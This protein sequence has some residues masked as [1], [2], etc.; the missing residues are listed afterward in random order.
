MM[1]T[2]EQVQAAYK[3]NLETLLGLTNK[4]FESVEKMAELNLAASKAALTEASTVAKATTSAKDV[5][6]VLALQASALQP[7]AEKT[8]AYSRELYDIASA[9]SAEC[10]KVCES[11]GAEAQK[12]MQDVLGNTAKNTP[13]GSEAVM[14]VIQNSMAAAN[15]AMESVQKAVKQANAV[16]DS[17]FKTMTENAVKGASASKKSK[18]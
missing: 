3:A 15:N 9:Y 8:A 13:P 7:L 10:S 12:N 11:K 1:V 14:A 16:A 17:N 4:A 2:A 5:Q 18:A 6:E